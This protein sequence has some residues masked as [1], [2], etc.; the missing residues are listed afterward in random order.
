MDSLPFPAPDKQGQEKQK[1]KK[2]ALLIESALLKKLSPCRPACPARIKRVKDGKKSE[3]IYQFPPPRNGAGSKPS[4]RMQRNV[5]HIAA[6]YHSGK[7]ETSPL[8][9]T[10]RKKLSPKEYL[11]SDTIFLPRV[12]YVKSK[13]PPL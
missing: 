10:S 7:E 6:W 12:A 9:K 4:F 5:P 11:V 8:S 3:Q 1:K 2:D 13:N